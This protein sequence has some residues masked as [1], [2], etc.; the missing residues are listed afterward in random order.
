ML[1]DSHCHL[2]MEE[3]DQDRKDVMER[4]RT[5]GLSHVLSVATEV[6]HFEKLMGILDEYPE[7]YGAI[8]IHPHNSKDYSSAVE[9]TVEMH[10]SHAKVVA[11]GE[12]GLDFYRD[13]SPRDIQ[14]SAFV[15][16]ISLARTHALPV[17]IHSRNAKEETLRLLRET[18]AAAHGG[19]IH[20]FSYDLDAARKLLDMGFHLSVPGTITYRSATQLSEVVKFCPLERLLAETDAPFLTPEPHRGKRNE[21]AFVALVFERIALLK[22]ISVEELAPAVSNNFMRLFLKENR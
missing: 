16:Q 5:G 1:I 3:Y 13:H 11:Y 4:A 21:P 14:I 22:E 19:V 6:G 15:A 12:I 7:V 10:L 2:E 9:K 20:C 8:G 17:I 18:D